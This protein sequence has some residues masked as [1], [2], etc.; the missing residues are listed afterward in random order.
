M[1]PKQFLLF[2]FAL[3]NLIGRAQSDTTA[4][5]QPFYGGAQIG[6]QNTFSLFHEFEFFSRPAVKLHTHVLAGIN[7]L[8]KNAVN[9]VRVRPVFGFQAG[10]LGLIGKKAL[11]GE[12]GVLPAVYSYK[13]AFVNFNGWVGLRLN[14]DASEQMFISLAYTPRLY[15]S[16]SDPDNRYFNAW[17]GFKFGVNF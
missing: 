2:V 14:I 9:E 12:I 6:G 17:I 8:G 11:V 15:T 5:A 16:Y 13:V 3:L 10:V 1:K 4:V 7:N